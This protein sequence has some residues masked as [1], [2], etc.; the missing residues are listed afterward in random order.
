MGEGLDHY[1]WC[2]SGQ[3]VLGSIRKQAEQVRKQAKKQHPSIAS[4][5]A[6]ASRI[7]PCLSSCPD[8]P[9]WWTMWKCKMNKPFP[10]QLVFLGMM[11]HHSNRNPHWDRWAGGAGTITPGSCWRKW[12]N[13]LYK[14]HTCRRCTHCK[15][16]RAVEQLLLMVHLLHTPLMFL[17]PTCSLG[18]TWVLI[19]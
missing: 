18:V 5:S 7:L 11:F 3:V 2:I 15:N 10:P 17:L 13:L 12:Q 9:W 6:P 4:A 8:F 16:Q 19:L 14:W 1:G